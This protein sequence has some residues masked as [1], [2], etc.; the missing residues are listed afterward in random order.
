MR[1]NAHGH[2]LQ[3][4]SKKRPVLEMLAPG[5][6]NQDTQRPNIPGLDMELAGDL[7]CPIAAPLCLEQA[8]QAHSRCLHLT[9]G[10]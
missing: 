8:P 10:C 4:G 5:Q 1:V 6:E 2:L 7:R 3:R 9:S